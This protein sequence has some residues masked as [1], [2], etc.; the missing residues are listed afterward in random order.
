MYISINPDAET[1]I[2]QQLHQQIVQLIATRKLPAGATL[3]PVRKVATQ[4]GINPATVKKAYDQLAR[5]GLV[6]TRDRS[7]TVVKEITSPLPT[8]REKLTTRLDH[9]TAL[10]HAQGFTTTEIIDIIKKL[11]R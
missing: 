5:D 4:F 1:P 10:A 7:G 11:S 2:F 6:E 3:T 8:Q 9:I